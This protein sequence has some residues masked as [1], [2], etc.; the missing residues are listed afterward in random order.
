MLIA[1][2]FM[3]VCASLFKA[4]SPHQTLFNGN[5]AQVS[6]GT[7]FDFREVRSS[8]LL[9]SATQFLQLSLRLVYVIYRFAIIE[10]TPVA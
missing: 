3:G 4:D 1:Y 9:L 7:T 6:Y 5:P 8:S 10:L 2:G